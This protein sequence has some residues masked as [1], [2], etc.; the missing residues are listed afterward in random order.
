MA[1]DGGPKYV[2]VY[3]IEGPQAYETPEFNAIKGFGPFTRYI[4]NFRRICLAPIS[5]RPLGSA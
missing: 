4:S 5:R 2:A 1:F 3:E